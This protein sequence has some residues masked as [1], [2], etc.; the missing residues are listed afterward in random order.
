VVDHPPPHR[1]DVTG[2]ADE[3]DELEELTAMRDAGG[4]AADRAD[5]ATRSASAY[6]DARRRRL[7]RELRRVG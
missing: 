1:P 6:L 2:D 3:L 4:R 5:R 7:K